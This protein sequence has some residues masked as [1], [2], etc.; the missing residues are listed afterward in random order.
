MNNTDMILVLQIIGICVIISII[1]ATM[2]VL[3]TNRVSRRHRDLWNNGRC[4]KCERIYKYTGHISIFG[5]FIFK[6]ECGYNTYS[7]DKRLSKD[8]VRVYMLIHWSNNLKYELSK[9]KDYDDIR[10]IHIL[11]RI[12]I[13]NEEISNIISKRKNKNWRDIIYE[14]QI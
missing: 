4:K 9:I 1:I 13:Y 2:I 3:C 8:F 14:N 5:D 11:N 7:I 10:K 6:C 12:N